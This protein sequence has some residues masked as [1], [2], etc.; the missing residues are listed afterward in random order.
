MRKEGLHLRT[1]RP[2]CEAKPSALISESQA[3]FSAL[4]GFIMD[5]TQSVFSFDNRASTRW[6]DERPVD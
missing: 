4:G 1:R 6:I 2:D 3:R 5:C